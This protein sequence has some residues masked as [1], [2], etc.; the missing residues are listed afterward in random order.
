ML[1]YKFTNTP[2]IARQLSI[3]IFRF[4]E[5]TKYIKMEDSVGRSDPAE[6]SVSFPEEEYRL[7]PDQIPIASFN[8]VE[9]KCISM[10]PGDD[11]IKQYFVFCMSTIIDDAVMGDSKYVVE[12]ST[13]MFETFEMV[14]CPPEN[15]H[16]NANGYKFFSHAPVAYYDIHQH[17]TL[18]GEK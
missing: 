3:G 9:F 4:Y 10:Q 12:L 1:L 2:E 6:C 13:D 18:L 16:L 8:G 14:L 7:F 5:L 11:H 15:A 17:P